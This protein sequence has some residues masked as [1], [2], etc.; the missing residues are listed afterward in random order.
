MHSDHPETHHHTPKHLAERFEGLIPI[1]MLIAI[2]VLAI[3]MI[4]G[5][6]HTDATPS[7][8]K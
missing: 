8:M 7:W 4:W 1:L 2:V 3:G 5:V 6:M